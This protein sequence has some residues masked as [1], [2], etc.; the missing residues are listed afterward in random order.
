MNTEI[1]I[2]LEDKVLRAIDSVAQNTGL[3]SRRAA[4]EKI[5][6]RWY[7][8]AWLQQDLDRETEAYYKSLTPEEIAEDRAWVQFASEQAMQRWDDR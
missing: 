6:Q 2:R 8:I 7:E 5:L 4:I 3:S 1:T